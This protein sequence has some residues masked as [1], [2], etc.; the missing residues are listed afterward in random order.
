MENKQQTN[1]EEKT[2]NGAYRYTY[3]ALTPEQKKEAESILREYEPQ[4]ERQSPQSDF[5][6]LQELQNRIARILLI[7]GLSMGII[8]C[9]I[10]GG[11]MSMVLLQKELLPCLIAGGTLCV[12]GIA[13]MI[14][15]PFAYKGM[16]RKLQEKHKEEIIR[17]CKSVLEEE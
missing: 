2:A 12:V 13:V 1:M 14:V 9:L 8:G 16:K 5:E 4:A 6:K 10:F 3:R 17:L 11:G 7:F 15:T